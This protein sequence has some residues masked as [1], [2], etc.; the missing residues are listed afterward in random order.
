MELKSTHPLRKIPCKVSN[1]LNIYWTSFSKM[2]K[3]FKNNQQYYFS[4]KVMHFYCNH[5]APFRKSRILN[6]W[7]KLYLVEQWPEHFKAISFSLTIP[8]G[9]PTLQLAIAFMKRTYPSKRGKRPTP[10]LPYKLQMQNPKRKEVIPPICAWHWWQSQ[11]L[12]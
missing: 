8:R 5:S 10:S 2:A 6:C 7:M 4:S 1:N 11:E 12:S 9:R 3:C